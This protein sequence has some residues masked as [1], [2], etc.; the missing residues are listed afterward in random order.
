MF[1][2][3]HGV[4][5][6]GIQTPTRNWLVH[7]TNL[8]N[9]AITR[10]QSQLII[11]GDQSWWSGQRGL[12]A[13]VAQG[14]NH[15]ESD[16]GR[17]VGPADQLH[18][19]LR[20][21]GLTVRRNVSVQGFTYDLVVSGPEREIVVLVDDPAGDPEGRAFRKILTRSDVAG[22]QATVLRVPVWRCLSQPD[23]VAAELLARFPEL[24]S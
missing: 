2:G 14:V 4:G 24:A 1:P 15:D 9:V 13:T 10:A 6:N 5:A 22:E 18:A 23:V 20:G 12:L 21:S 8:W 3:F 19:A 11:V 16:S 17:P 7:Q